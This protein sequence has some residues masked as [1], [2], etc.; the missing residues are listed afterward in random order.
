MGKAKPDFVTV[1]EA[2]K[3]LGIQGRQVRNLIRNGVLAAQQVGRAY[4]INRADLAKVPKVR[5]PGPK[6]K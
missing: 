2:G 1:E 6:G 4:I 5:K 3:V